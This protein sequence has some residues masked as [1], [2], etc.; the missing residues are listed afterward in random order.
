[1]RT[2]GS[3]WI[4]SLS[5]NSL[6]NA[7]VSGNSDRRIKEN[8]KE[9]DTSEALEK[10]RRLR[11]VT[12][13]YIDR[14]SDGLSNIG[15]IAQEV[16][17]VVPQA[18]DNTIRKVVPDV[19]MFATW[20]K[21]LVT[22]KKPHGMTGEGT[23]QVVLQS[24]E[25]EIKKDWTFKVLNELIVEV[26]C[27]RSESAP[28]TETIFVYGTYVEDFHIL[29]DKFINVIGI[30]ALKELDKRISRIEEILKLNRRS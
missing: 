6:D 16:I 21:N 26:P 29:G 2:S 7:F 3:I 18:V 20:C 11:P 22:F 10:V 14:F 8:I 1:M 27:G 23:L 24:G 25:D 4:N 17:K 9:I 5:G 15:Y 30:S 19:F 28:E 12:Y 13:D